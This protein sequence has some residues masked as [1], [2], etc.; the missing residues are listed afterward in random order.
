[1][2]TIGDNEPPNTNNG[3]RDAESAVISNNTQNGH[4]PLTKE[5]TLEETLDWDTCPDN[6]WNWPLRKKVLQVFMLS[7]GA[8]LA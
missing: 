5:K 7:T 8:L 4:E 6:P 1:M 3:D 2:E